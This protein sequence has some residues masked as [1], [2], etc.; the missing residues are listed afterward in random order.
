MDTIK[1]AGRLG[2]AQ[3]GAAIVAATN[4]P[5]PNDLTFTAP[6][7]RD[8]N[9]W[10]TSIDLPDK[11]A[12][13]L[14][15]EPD[16]LA[17]TLNRAAG[18][19][20][21]TRE[22]WPPN[23]RHLTLQIADEPHWPADDSLDVPQ[24]DVHTAFGLSYSN[25]LVVPRTLLQSMPE[26]WQHRFVTLLDELYAA[27]AHVEQANNYIVTAATECTYSDL[28]DRDMAVLGVTRPDTPDGDDEDADVYYDRDGTEHEPEDRVLTPAPGGD[29]V[30]HYTRGRTYIEPRI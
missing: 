16:R 8:G 25:Y 4:L 17:A 27:F 13:L 15:N 6:I 5:N 20:E 26:F 2:A 14:A 23:P 19:V 24:K 10:T 7:R 3:L 18:T 1:T 12:D 11:A 28:S 30:P 29:P 21:A 22:D 9:G